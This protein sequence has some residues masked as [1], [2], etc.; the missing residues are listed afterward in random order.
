MQGFQMDP[1]WVTY[2]PTQLW[3]V[4]T[5]LGL[6]FTLCVGSSILKDELKFLI[7]N[8]NALL[9]I[10]PSV[11]EVQVPIRKGIRHKICAKNQSL[12]CLYQANSHMNLLHEEVKPGSLN[13]AG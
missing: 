6:G 11:Q 2:G 4:L 1:N 9:S 8:V 10:C 12:C 5:Q 13:K 3:V 7:S